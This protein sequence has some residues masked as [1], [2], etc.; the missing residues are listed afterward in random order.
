[1]ITCMEMKSFILKYAS[2]IMFYHVNIACYQTLT[3]CAGPA[4]MRRGTEAT[5]QGRAWP[6]RGAGGTDT[7]QEAT[8]VHADAREGRHMARGRWQLEG[9]WVSGP[10]L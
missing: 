3:W 1:M 4:R 8:R 5:W 6:T 7:W 2:K 9:P 10:W